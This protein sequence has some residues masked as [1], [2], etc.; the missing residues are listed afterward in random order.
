LLALRWLTRRE[1]SREELTEKLK[2]KG[3]PEPL[4]KEVAA[5]LAAEG[6]LSD[7]RYAEVIV[8]SRRERGHGPLRIAKEL[9]EKGLTQEAIERW[10]DPRSRDWIAQARR[11]R[12]RRFGT[13]PP[14]DY[15]ERAKQ[16]RFL[17]YRGFTFEQIQRA[18]K[19]GEED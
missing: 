15:A 7:E 2:Q 12:R 13:R 19:E 3:C 17:Q 5:R 6:L 8:R 9:Q 10:V 16:A 18:L 11:A 1:H 14:K 4:A